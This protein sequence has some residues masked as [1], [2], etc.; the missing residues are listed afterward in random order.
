M[1]KNFL[2][3]PFGFS[4]IKTTR[5]AGLLLAGAILTGCP[6]NQPASAPE[7]AAAPGTVVIRGSNTIGEELAPKLIADFKKDHAAVTFDV[8]PKATG[9]GL[10][11]L[12][13]G[14]C[15]I[16]AASRLAIKDEVEE[17]SRM[18]MQLQDYMIGTYSVAVVVNPKSTV[19]NLTKRQV[20]DVFTGAVTNWAQVGGADAA[21]H[22]YVRDPISGTYLGFRELATRSWRPVTRTSRKVS[23][24]T[25]MESA[26]A[27]WRC[28]R[29][30]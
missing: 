12:R 26:I 3:A 5:A 18:G 7:P 11:A 10:A 24:R 29:Q 20:K 19:A 28:P 1:K 2:A 14:K 17:A 25:K 6:A 15:D 23:P 27:A 8:Q 22:L 13:A 9:Y 30:R 4:G 21:I 16:A